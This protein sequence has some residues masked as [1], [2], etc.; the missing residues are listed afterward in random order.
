MLR[1]K[2]DSI[3]GPQGSAIPSLG[4]FEG[5]AFVLRVMA[6]VA[7]TRLLRRRDANGQ[8]KLIKALQRAIQRKCEQA[9]LPGADIA[10]ASKYAEGVFGEALNRGGRSPASRRQGPE[11]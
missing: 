9:K 6:T 4:D 1:A 11:P 7:L 5:R 10:A 8:I 3:G 2:R